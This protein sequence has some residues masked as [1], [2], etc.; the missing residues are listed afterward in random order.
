MLDEELTRHLHVESLRRRALHPEHEPQVLFQASTI[1]ALLDGGYDGDV[2]FA[3]L[4]GHGDLGLGTLN[5]LDGEM[6]AL[7]GH[8]YRADADGA[9]HDVP[10]TARTP[11]AVIGWFEP[12]RERTLDDGP[13]EH[14]EL[15]GVLDSLAGDS[16]SACALRVDGEFEFVRARSMPRQRRPYRPLADVVADQHVFALEDVDGTLVGFRFPSYAEG[17]EVAGYHL[18]FITAGRD[19]GGHVLDSRLRG[20][21]AALDPAGEL[22]VEL[23][24]GVEF[25]APQLDAATHR[26]IE[27]VERQG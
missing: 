5:A 6:I 19:R 9:I 14:G 26:A 20:G 16:D 21:T 2:T 11:F 3:E 12:R 15:L 8:F 17:L 7:D 24:P 4:A 25:D 13:L 10:P 23:P 1:G 22:H 18:H 27:R